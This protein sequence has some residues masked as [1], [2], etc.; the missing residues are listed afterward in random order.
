MD[1]TKTIYLDV[2]EKDEWDEGHVAGALHF[3]LIRL[4]LG[5]FPDIPKDSS[6]QVY[7]RSGG[8]AVMAKDLLDEAGFSNITNAGGL[9]DLRAQG[10]TVE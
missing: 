10:V 1:N 6:I 8:R 3:P 4:Q 7:C 9:E 5:D 2:R